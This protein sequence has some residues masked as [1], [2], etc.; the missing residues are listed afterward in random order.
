MYE[1]QFL[2]RPD[3]DRFPA[4]PIGIGHIYDEPNH[5]VNGIRYGADHY[6]IHVVAKGTGWLRTK[7]GSIELK[8]GMGFLYAEDQEQHFGSDPDD[9]WEVWWIYLRGEGMNDLIGEKRVGDVWAFA[10]DR[11]E[12]LHA[13]LQELWQAAAVNDMAAVP[14]HAAI[15]YELV[16][17]LVL[18][19]T[20]LDAPGEPG[21]V[22]AIKRAADFMRMHCAKDLPLQ[23]LADQC[24]ISPAYFSRTF[25]AQM[26]MPPLAYLN[27]QRIELSKQMLITTAKPVKQIA[28]EVGFS[29]PSYYIERFRLAEGVTPA[30]F[31]DRYMKPDA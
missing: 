20:D 10:Y 13:L 8:P 22:Q 21:L 18:H 23:K 4:Y 26:G 5:L 6:N 30:L 3:F 9:P 29:K 12:R 24:G 1:A 28:Q 16:L 19:S 27:R 2:A 7:A 31:R 25:H 11:G 14:R 17:E 15:L